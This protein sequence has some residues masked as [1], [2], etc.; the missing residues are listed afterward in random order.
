MPAPAP[1]AGEVARVGKEGIGVELQFQGLSA[2]IQG[3][4]STSEFVV[5]V[6]KGLAPCVASEF[7]VVRLTWDGETRVGTITLELE[8]ADLACLPKVGP[9]GVDLSAL[10]PLTVA[11][12][13]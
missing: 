11:L 13:G 9:D 3:F 7:A 8:P 10:M 12:A 1:T 5:D 4:F 2:L 6:G